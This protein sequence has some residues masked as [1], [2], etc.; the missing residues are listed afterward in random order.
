MDQFM[1]C[2]CKG[3][4]EALIIQSGAA[5]TGLPGSKPTPAALAAAWKELFFEYCD[6]AEATE[7]KY[8]AKLMGTVKALE[9][10][11]ALTEG[12][13]KI[14]SVIYM[15]ALVTGLREIGY[16][17]DFD[18]TDEQAYLY[19]LARVKGELASIKLTYKVKTA[20]LQALTEKHKGQEAMD[21]K[22]FATIFFN[23]NNYA[24]REA[25]TG[26]TT[27]ENYCAA[28][29]KYKE[30]LDDLKLKFNRHG[31]I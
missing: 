19:D 6:L 10:K 12:W 7:T 20:E 24:G 27:V 11:I 16:D 30:H 25:I 9:N 3:N 4:L 1:E 31:R 18:T 13:V 22:Y 23:I 28:L 21:R 5:G 17:Y 8:R 2:L 14:L 26:Q 29:R 15:P